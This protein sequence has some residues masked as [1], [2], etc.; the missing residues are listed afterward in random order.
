MLKEIKNVKQN[1]EETGYRK[2]FVD[3]EIDLIVWFK[4]EGKITGFQ[5]CYDK[6][7]NEHVFTWTE[8][9]GFEH[10]EMDSGEQSPLANRTPIL[11]KDGPFPFDRVQRLF[12]S[13]SDKIDSNIRDLI[14]KKISEFQLR[15]PRSTD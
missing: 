2:W 12:Q 8:K 4:D 5:L 11:I 13:H 15:K 1:A 14:L 9:N 6:N 7:Q 3:Q 10:D